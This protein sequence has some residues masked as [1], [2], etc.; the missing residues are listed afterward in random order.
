MS[1]TVRTRGSA[2]WSRL[3]T[4]HLAVVVAASV[5]LAISAA[6]QLEF[7]SIVVGTLTSV[8]GL[9]WSAL[10]PFAHVD[11]GP[12][13]RLWSV[14]LFLPPFVNVALHQRLVVWS[15]SRERRDPRTR[16]LARHLGRIDRLDRGAG[17]PPRRPRRRGRAGRRPGVGLR[18]LRPGRRGGVGG[19]WLGWDTTYDTV[20]GVSEPQGPYT[21]AQVVACA[22]TLAVATAALARWRDP[23]VVASGV[24]FGFWAPW[25]A[26][27][28]AGP[29]SGSLWAVG[30][31]MLL[32]ALVAGTG[33]MAVLGYASRRWRTPTPGQPAPGPPGQWWRTSVALVVVGGCWLLVGAVVRLVLPLAWTY[34]RVLHVPLDA[35]AA[36]R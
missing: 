35:V 27:A 33:V 2:R 18:R 17:Q 20:P 5:A 9:P 23:L 21:P 6:L 12:V 15:R 14:V 7:A 31:A 30:S 29:L 13:D 32:F 25:T 16:H 22:V 19:A 24:T 28:A 4:W 11:L 26:M 1:A 34:L 3:L 8:L 10:L 36:P